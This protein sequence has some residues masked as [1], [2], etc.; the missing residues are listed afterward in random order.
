[1]S[2]HIRVDG[3][4]LACEDGRSRFHG[5]TYKTLASHTRMANE[6]YSCRDFTR[7]FSAIAIAGLRHLHWQRTASAFPLIGPRCERSSWAQTG[8]ATWRR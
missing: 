6:R 3:N 2:D 8:V 4:G 7:D 1:M 5:V